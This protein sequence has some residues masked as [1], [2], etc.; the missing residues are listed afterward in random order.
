MDGAIVAEALARLF[1]RAEVEA[2]DLAGFRFKPGVHP[3]WMRSKESR[4]ADPA[5]AVAEIEEITAMILERVRG[6]AA[7]SP[8]AGR[9]RW[10]GVYLAE[11]VNR[12][13]AESPGLHVGWKEDRVTQA[14][15]LASN[16][17]FVD[18]LR[19]LRT[20]G[21][22]KKLLNARGAESSRFVFQVWDEVLNERASLLLKAELS[23]VETSFLCPLPVDER[24]IVKVL[25]A[26]ESA[27][28]AG[29]SDRADIARKVFSD[30]LAG[31][32]ESR[33]EEAC[34]VSPDLAAS[35]ERG[36]NRRGM[37]SSFA[38]KRDNLR[39]AWLSIAQGEAGLS[40][41]LA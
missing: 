2:G 16:P 8:K 19:Q 38:A 33:W 7:Q 35:A 13:I 22:G 10:A 30:L 39:E 32:L 41:L 27:L 15:A 21:P 25:G 23:R 28:R 36:A 31:V 24:R 37:M 29:R 18:R 12:L 26:A 1:A 14:T 11:L 9:G 40:R 34:R 3:D 20:R 5:C 4:E 6:W 17:A